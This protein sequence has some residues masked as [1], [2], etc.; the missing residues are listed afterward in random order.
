MLN[1]TPP[2]IE[3][4]LWIPETSDNVAPGLYSMTTYTQSEYATLTALHNH[5]TNIDNTFQ[6]E[7]NNKFRN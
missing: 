4:Y 3:N 2:L 6:T 5:I 7:I 1:P